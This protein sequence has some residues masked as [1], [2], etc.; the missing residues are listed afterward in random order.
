MLSAGELARLFVSVTMMGDEAAE[1]V[2]MAPVG[3]WAADRAKLQ[4]ACLGMLAILVVSVGGLA[5][6]LPAAIPAMA[7]GIAGNIG[8]NLLLRL[9]RPAPIRR[10][11]LRRNHKGWGGL[12][13]LAGFAFSACW[14][15]ATWQMLRGSAWA[16]VPVGLALLGLWAC[17]PA[18]R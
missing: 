1:L 9:W 12:V 18:K 7:V 11:D 17:K 14:S 2:R 15:V 10:T 16:L 4:A 5:I 8:C 6:S 13:N 3:R